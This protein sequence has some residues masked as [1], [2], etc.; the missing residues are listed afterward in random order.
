MDA[1]VKRHTAEQLNRG[2]PEG[3]PNFRKSVD[4]NRER[5]EQRDIDRETNK[6]IKESGGPSAAHRKHEREER[7]AAVDKSV[8]DTDRVLND[9]RHRN[10]RETFRE[11]FQ[12]FFGTSQRSALMMSPRCGLNRSPRPTRTRAARKPAARTCIRTARPKPKSSFC[13]SGVSS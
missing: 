9:R 1:G 2:Y 5:R 11:T 7:K 4:A 3:P 13:S 12:R 6:R 10:Y 8:A